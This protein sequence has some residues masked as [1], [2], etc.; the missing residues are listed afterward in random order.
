MKS[1][2]SPHAIGAGKRIYFI[3]LLF[4]LTVPYYNKFGWVNQN[5]E[6]REVSTY[7]FCGVC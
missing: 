6:N 5:K 2:A 4:L 3:R 1:A 7:G